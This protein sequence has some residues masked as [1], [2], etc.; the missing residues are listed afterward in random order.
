MVPVTSVVRAS[1]VRKRGGQP[2]AKKVERPQSFWHGLCSTCDELAKNAAKR[3]SLVAFLR[4]DKAGPDMDCSRPNC[5]VFGK[6]HKLFKEGKL[7]LTDMR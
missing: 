2:G 1:N 4:A 5:T 7:L 3:I 6:K